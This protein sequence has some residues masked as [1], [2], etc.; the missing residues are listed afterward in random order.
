MIINPHFLFSVR[1]V[2]VG[3]PEKICGCPTE[4]LRLK[5]GKAVAVITMNGK[6]VKNICPL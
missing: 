2:P 1:Y 6:N 4:A 3:I 5:P